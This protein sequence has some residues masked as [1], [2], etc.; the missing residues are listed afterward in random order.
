MPKKTHRK[1]VSGSKTNN[2]TR[3]KVNKKKDVSSET[4]PILNT[5]VNKI[6]DLNPFSGSTDETVSADNIE[7]AISCKDKRCPS[8]Y[9]CN[10]ENTFRQR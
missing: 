7:Q 5:I 2:T 3:R 9:R 8:G 1:Q 4:Q 10:K 6:S